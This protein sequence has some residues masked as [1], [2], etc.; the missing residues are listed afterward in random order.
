MG[1]DLDALTEVGVKVRDLYAGGSDNAD[2]IYEKVDDQYIAGLAQA[3]TGGLGGNVGVAPRLF[4]KKLVGGVLDVVDQ[5]E[6]FNPREDYAL[7][8]SDSELTVEEAAAAANKS[9]DDIDLEL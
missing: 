3:V 4:L 9:V 7:K 6:D 1:F 5:H 8:V 2:R